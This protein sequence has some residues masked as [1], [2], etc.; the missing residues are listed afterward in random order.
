ME[1]NTLLEQAK[2]LIQAE[3]RAVTEVAG[4]LG[5]PF[6]DAVLLVAQ[7]P[8]VIMTTGSGTSGAI[9]R[10]LAHLLAT[11]GMHA[12]FAPPADAL[13][14]P[15]AAVA[16]GDVLIA[17][18][19]AGKSA[20]I[21]HFA[22]VARERGGKVISLTWKPDSELGGLS[23]VV[24]TL[25]AAVYAEGEGVLP[26]GST[27][28][29]GALCDALCLAAKNLR[30]FDLTTLAQTHPSGATAELVRKALT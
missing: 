15:S 1:A 13:H 9:A 2:A 7:C 11:C 6:V 22:R 5:Q 14:G 23:D 25:P 20:E 29:A 17:L 12:F 10:R 19:K 21:N 16:P 26:F 24:L 18:S 8:G 4:G 30:G 3:G 28:A 27:L